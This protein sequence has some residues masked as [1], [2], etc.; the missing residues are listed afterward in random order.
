MGAAQAGIGSVEGLVQC[1]EVLVYRV[2][3]GCSSGSLWYSRVAELDPGAVLGPIL[4]RD[5]RR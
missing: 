1:G 4:M 3:V 5:I 2:L